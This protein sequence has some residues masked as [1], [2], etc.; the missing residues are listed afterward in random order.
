MA[1]A[2]TPTTSLPS[3][4]IRRVPNAKKN[5]K[6]GMVAR[7]AIVGRAKDGQNHPKK[8][9]TL[10][11]SVLPFPLRSGRK[12]EPESPQNTLLPTPKVTGKTLNNPPSGGH[13]SLL[14]PKP[15][16][17][18]TGQKIAPIVPALSVTGNGIGREPSADKSE[19]SSPARNEKAVAA[20]MQSLIGFKS[21]SPKRS[22]Q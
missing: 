17:R 10:P 18:P 19:S 4:S 7:A 8:V 20:A 3:I 14:S 15:P 6:V 13:S 21:P 2:I 22:G 1:T 5:E 16:A 11:L 9:P 12:M